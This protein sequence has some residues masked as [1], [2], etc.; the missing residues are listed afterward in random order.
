MNVDQVAHNFLSMSQH[1]LDSAEVLF[2]EFRFSHSVVLLGRCLEKMLKGFWVLKFHEHPP[3][4]RRLLYLAKKLDLELDEPRIRLLGALSM[5]AAD[6]EDLAA[7]KRVRLC[8]KKDVAADY[9]EK[10][11]RLIEWLKPMLRR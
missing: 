8:V 5:F 2:E 10:T 4:T 6:Y 3:V 9:Q 11:E 1:D 7:W